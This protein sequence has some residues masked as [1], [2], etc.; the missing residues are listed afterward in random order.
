MCV[1]LFSDAVQIMLCRL[2]S[3]C[4]FG[5]FRRFLDLEGVCFLHG[6]S[7]S[8]ATAAP[9]GELVEAE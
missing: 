4:S 1:C 3:A 7:N 5:L 8:P 6:G 2:C 9:V